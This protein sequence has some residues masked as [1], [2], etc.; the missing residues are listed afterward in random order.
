MENKN[1]AR[2]NLLKVVFTGLM[3]ALVC[4]ATAVLVIPLPTS[5]YANLGDCLV[6]ISGYMLGPVYGALASGIGAGLSDLFL[7]YGI[8]APF[9]FLIKAV[10]AIMVYYITKLGRE[11]SF[12]IQLLFTVIA[13]IVAE[14]IM[15]GGYFTLEVFLY[16]VEGAL[17]NIFGNSMQGIF[18]CLSASILYTVMGKANL[19]K[20]TDKLL[21][22]NKKLTESI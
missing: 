8:Y 14:V 9:T 7:G 3:A 19:F 6:I 18:G 4:V 1:S 20:I 2:E 21:G 11:R 17:P 16:G 12:G 15:V 10:M 5:G 22:R 13:A